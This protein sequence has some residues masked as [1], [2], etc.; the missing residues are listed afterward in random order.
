MV[1][2]VTGASGFIGTH[3]VARLRACGYELRC[4]LER[5]SD[6]CA[7]Q[8]TAVEFCE[9]DIADPGLTDQLHRW[10]RGVDAVIHL[11]GLTT[12]ASAERMRQV[13]VSGTATLAQAC[14]GQPSPPVFIHVSSLAAAGPAMGE[15]VRV[16]EDP[17]RPI[18]RYGRTKLAGERALRRF[19]DQLPATIVRPGMAFGP[20]DRKSLPI[21]RTIR[22]GRFHIVPGWRSPPLSLI[23]VEDLADILLR[24]IAHGQRISAQESSPRGCYFAADEQHPT[25]AELG[26]IV[27]GMMNRPFAPVIHAPYSFLWACANVSEWL[28]ARSGK[29]AFFNVDKL[30]ES[31]VPSWA[32]SPESLFRELQFR[33]PFDLRQRLQQTVDWYNREGWL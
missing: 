32:C 20:H 18:S 11:A 25:Y 7:R 27:R 9:G 3:L 13:N 22:R 12:A 30:R 6:I 26:R 33:P 10:L 4:L 23:Y 21:F 1:V 19:A 24:L 31:A 5:Q 29:P 2:F 15:Q 8:A 17:P 28:A 14:A 16:P